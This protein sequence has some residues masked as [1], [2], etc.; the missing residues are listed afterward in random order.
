MPQNREDTV[1][2]TKLRLELGGLKK[3]QIINLSQIYTNED[4]YWTNM[5]NPWSTEKLS[6]GEKWKQM[7]EWMY[8][9]DLWMCQLN[10]KIKGMAPCHQ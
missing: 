4:T 6:S 7:I 5:W 9:L 3:I 2:E 1:D 10:T 8:L